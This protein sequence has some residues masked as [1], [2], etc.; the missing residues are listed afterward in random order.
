MASVFNGGYKSMTIWFSPFLKCEITKYLNTYFMQTFEEWLNKNHPEAMDENWRQTMGALAMA[1]ASFLPMTNAQAA[2]PTAP[3]VAATQ[4][5]SQNQQAR[6]NAMKQVSAVHRFKKNWGSEFNPQ[7]DQKLFDTIM[8][9]QTEKDH[10]DFIKMINNEMDEIRRVQ[11][12]SGH[13]KKDTYNMYDYQYM[14]YVRTLTYASKI[15]L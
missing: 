13:N 6:L 2:P 5:V 1:G 8:R 10:D 15:N 4:S 11:N 7:Q 14:E 3:K 9:L 12:I